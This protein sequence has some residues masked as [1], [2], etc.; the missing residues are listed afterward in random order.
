MTEQELLAIE[1]QEFS[2][3]PLSMLRGLLLKATQE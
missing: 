2:T 3:G 1:E